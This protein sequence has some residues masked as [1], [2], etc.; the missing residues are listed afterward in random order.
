MLLAI[1]YPPT[2]LRMQL[3]QGVLT[4][5]P[6]RS[7]AKRLQRQRQQSSLRLRFREILSTGR[8]PLGQQAIQKGDGGRKVL[9][10]PSLVHLLP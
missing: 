10:Y 8:Y 4:A 6:A 5:A 2:S 7:K 9:T 1:N 3:V